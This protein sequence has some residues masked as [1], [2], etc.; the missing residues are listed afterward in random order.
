M[1]KDLDITFN[2]LKVDGGMVENNLLMQFQSDILNKNIVA[3]EIKEI[4]AYGAALASY[5]FLN[6]ININEVD[7]KF[8][9]PSSWAPNMNTEIRKNHLTKWNKA[10]ERSKKWI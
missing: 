5:I 7:I 9:N 4:T 3:R 6:K 1:E 10:I 2:E 8:N